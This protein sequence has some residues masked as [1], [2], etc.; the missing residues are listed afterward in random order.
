MEVLK[1]L[2][3]GNIAKQKDA[4]CRIRTCEANATDLEPVPFDHSG[5]HAD[6][7]TCVIRTHAC[8]AHR[9]SRAAR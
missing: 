3:D 5:N 6:G 8:R 2:L 7:A 4:W 1:Y 9:L